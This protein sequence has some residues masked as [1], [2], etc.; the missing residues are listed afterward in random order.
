MYKAGRYYFRKK[1]FSETVQPQERRNYISMEHEVLN[2]MDNH[3]HT[4]MNNTDF[5]PA[6]GYGDFCQAHVELLRE[7]I[8]RLC[9]AGQIDA[10]SLAAKIKKTYKNRYFMISRDMN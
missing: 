9:D 1:D 3:I 10:Q 7:E 4:I 5:T 2:A 6:N 8:K